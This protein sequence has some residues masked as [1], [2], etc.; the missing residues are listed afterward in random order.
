MDTRLLKTGTERERK[1]TVARAAALLKSGGIVALPTETVYGIAALN[2][3]PEAIARLHQ[4]KQRSNAKPTTQAFPDTARA[5]EQAARPTIA[6]QRLAARYWPGPLTLVVESPEGGTVGLRVPGLDVTREILEQTR[7]GVLLPSANP[8]GEKPATNAEQVAAY[9]GGQID[10]IVD[11]G[12]TPLSQSSTVVEATLERLTVLREGVLSRSEVESIAIHD[13]LFVCSG[14]TCRSPMAAALMKAAL[15]RHHA[16]PAEQLEAIGFK[17]GSAGA[18]AMPGQ[19]ASAGAL[20]AM[21]SRAI[22]LTAHRSRPLTRELLDD[23]DH[24][25]VMTRSLLEQLR[26]IARHPERLQLVDD[27]DQDVVDPFGGSNAVYLRCAAQLEEAVGRLAP[28]L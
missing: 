3:H 16:I 13:V 18:A 14:N 25:F 9:Y 20:R 8:G 15:A 27:R 28:R 26:S 7:S 4:L 21:E 6:A 5:F 11:A 17:V 1:E 24:V 19:M 10:A 23:Q 2:G 12:K 22:D